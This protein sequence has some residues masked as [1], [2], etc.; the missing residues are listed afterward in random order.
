MWSIPISSIFPALADLFCVTRNPTKKKI[1][2]YKSYKWIVL[3]WSATT[4]ATVAITTIPMVAIIKQQQQH[5]V[6]KYAP[7]RLNEYEYV[8]LF[9]YHNENLPST[10][11]LFFF[12]FSIFSNKSSWMPI[13][14]YYMFHCISISFSWWRIFCWN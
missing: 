14:R 10:F 11:F 12:F 7:R 8:L 5:G 2:Q 6:I 1:D 3:R 9:N 13:F 4:D